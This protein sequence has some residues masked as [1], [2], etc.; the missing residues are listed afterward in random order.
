MKRPRS[1]TG[2][3]GAHPVDAPDAPPRGAPLGGTDVEAAHRLQ[4]GL[5]GLG[6]MVLLI[7]LA[8]VLGNQADLAEEN[9]VPEAA[10]TTE[11]EETAPKRDPLADAGIVPDVS[12][13]PSPS[14]T[15]TPQDVAPP[16]STTPAQN[17][18]PDPQP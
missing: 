1:L 6:S 15:A 16:S 7:A 9:S 14:P 13:E 2:K 5:A 12:A 11:P 8:S 17:G 18:T 4:I 10:P 3:V